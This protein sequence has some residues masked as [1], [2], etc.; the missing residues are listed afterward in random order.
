MGFVGP[1]LHLGMARCEPNKLCMSQMQ[2]CPLCL[3]HEFPLTSRKLTN[4]ALAQH[5]QSAH[6]SHPCFRG[7]EKARPWQCQ[8]CPGG[9]RTY[10]TAI[11]FADHLLQ[12]H[13]CQN[14][15]NPLTTGQQIQGQNPTPSA[16]S[17]AAA[18][19]PTRDQPVVDDT[20]NTPLKVPCL[21]WL[22]RPKCCLPQPHGEARMDT[23]L[24]TERLSK[25]IPLQVLT[26]SSCLQ[27]RFKFSPIGCVAFKPSSR[28]GIIKK[29]YDITP[30]RAAPKDLLYWQVHVYPVLL[31][32][33]PMEPTTH[34]LSQHLPLLMQT[35]PVD[36]RPP[37]PSTPSLFTT[38]SRY[39]APPTAVP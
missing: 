23:S 18:S 9:R 26:L 12:F 17:A 33:A 8:V 30:S 6:I 15:P 3:Q 22:S 32:P 38:A 14:R 2:A 19:E 27:S 35:T 7:D 39:P 34:A 21:P 1:R 37:C 24:P 31:T 28:V 16:P 36:A 13:A 29:K 25:S 10:G 4:Q 20:W 11:T 5:L